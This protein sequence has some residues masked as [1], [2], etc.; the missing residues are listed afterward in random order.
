MAKILMIDDD[1]DLTEMVQM[2]LSNEG[3]ET[4]VINTG[5]GAFE[6]AKQV[7]PDI[8][9][10]DIMLPGVTG[11]QIA[12]RIRKDP[13]LY[14]MAVL[15]LT[16]LGEE[17]EILHGLEQGADDYLIKPFKMERLLEKLLAMTSLLASIEKRSPLTNLPGTDA[18]KREI[19]FRLVRGT[20]IAAVYV[21]VANFKAYCAAK[22]RDG[23][24]VVLQFV[25]KMLVNV[26]RSLSIYESFIAHMG[27]EHFV[28]VVNLEDYERFCKALL[29]T[30]DR[31]IELFYSPQEMA[32]GYIMAG[33]RRGQE[34][35][36]PLMALS[37]GVA[38]TQFRKF[39]SA[40]KMFEVLAQVRQMAQ[41]DGQSVMFV[42]RRHTDR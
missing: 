16:A 34:V 29:Q 5:D 40:K 10:L 36:C 25:A 41:P 21:D 27:G 11:F 17:P 26:T 38:H 8:A 33:D 7:K 18:I 37:V 3:Y 15:I 4:F 9:I 30:F 23:Q 31:N 28:T 6:L 35:R 39:K 1:V 22:G 13:E 2:K 42:D 19:D 14:R 12:R 24:R 32:Q 20:P